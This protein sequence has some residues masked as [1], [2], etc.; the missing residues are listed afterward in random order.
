MREFWENYR[1][2]LPAAAIGLALLIVIV[3]VAGDGNDDGVAEQPFQVTEHKQ[4]AK[5]PKPAATA[6]TGATAAV[7]PQSTE[8]VSGP[9]DRP[10]PILMYHVI[11]APP[12]GTPYP[13][14]WVKPADFKRQMAW[15]AENGFTGITMAQLF[16]YWDQ[17]FK[18]PA[19]PVVISFD[20]GYPSHAK[21][22][23]PVLAAHHWPGV[24]FLETGNV[25]NPE[26]GFTVAMVRELIA[27][28]WEIDS[29]TITHP[30]LTTLDDAELRRELVGSRTKIKRMFGQPAQF[31]AYPAGK[32]DAGVVAAVKAAGYKAAVTE[33][34]G[35]ATPDKPFELDRVRVDGSGG[36]DGFVAKMR[37]V[38]Q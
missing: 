5:A 32:Y 1:R 24:L 10:V 15:L 12:L 30:D 18:L 7:T 19:K 36:L 14:L 20:D 37:S 29:H 35:I 26:S 22:A 8:R 25:G 33:I 13:E 11:K 23:R 21:H 17:G 3:I 27:A 4:P 38:G 31:F 2:Y 34:E 9:H 16:K 28:G 6:A